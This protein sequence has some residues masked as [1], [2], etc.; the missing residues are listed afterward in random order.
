MYTMP[1]KKLHLQKNPLFKAVTKKSGPYLPLKPP[2]PSWKTLWEGSQYWY[3]TTQARFR[4]GV[5]PAYYGSTL[6][7]YTNV[8]CAAKVCKQN[9]ISM[10]RS[11]PANTRSFFEGDL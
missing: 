2:D 5:G 3:S 4:T 10:A 6:Y 1:L 7:M 11:M 8:L 9:N